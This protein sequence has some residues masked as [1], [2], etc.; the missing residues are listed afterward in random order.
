MPIRI[1]DVNFFPISSPKKGFIGF[2]SVQL[3][4]WLELNS[5]GCHTLL[6]DPGQ[7][8]ITFPAR[9]LGKGKY[10]FYFKITNPKVEKEITKAIKK[11]IERLGLFS[12]KTPEK[13]NGKEK[14]NK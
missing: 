9:K 5:L 6:N 2:A 3:F 4:D 12:F 10:K 1:T 13:E 7:I 14:E 11:E 8:R